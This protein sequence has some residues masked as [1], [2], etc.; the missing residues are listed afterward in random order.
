VVEEDAPPPSDPVAEDAA[1]RPARNHLRLDDT[2][3][4]RIVGSQAGH[5]AEPVT[6]VGEEWRRS[7]AGDGAA[8]AVLHRLRNRMAVEEGFRVLLHSWVAVDDPTERAMGVDQTNE[9]WVVGERVVVKWMTDDLD[10]RRDPDA[11]RDDRVA[12]PQR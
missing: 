2:H 10:V 7:V 4:I 8:A 6:L 11:G 5:R 1:L 12:E 9:S 3:A